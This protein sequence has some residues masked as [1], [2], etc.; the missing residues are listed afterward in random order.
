MR[1]CWRASSCSNV[2]NIYISTPNKR[3]PRRSTVTSDTVNALSISPPPPPHPPARLFS[4]SLSL[5]LSLSHRLGSSQYALLHIGWAAHCAL[6]F[7]H[8]EQF[9]AVLITCS[10]GSSL[11]LDLCTAWSAHSSFHSM[12]CGQLTALLTLCSVGGSQHF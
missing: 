12:P 11:H 7:M 2:C 10:V 8:C 9:I 6:D 3:P 5:S 4:L 1:A